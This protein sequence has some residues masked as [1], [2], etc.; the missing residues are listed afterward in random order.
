MELHREANGALD[1]HVVQ[2]CRRD[3]LVLARRHHAHVVRRVLKDEAQR[4][5]LDDETSPDTV[6]YRMG[7]TEPARRGPFVECRSRPLQHESV[8]QLLLI[9][10]VDRSAVATIRLCI[11]PLLTT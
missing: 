4:A 11:A 7:A 9:H 10:Q 5:R 3:H 8:G 2:P 1:L 6:S